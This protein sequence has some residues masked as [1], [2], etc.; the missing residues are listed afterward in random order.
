MSLQLLN[1]EYQ[2]ELTTRRK[3]S[4][5]TTTVRSVFQRIR[6]ENIGGLIRRGYPD[7][8]KLESALARLE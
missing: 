8:R 4:R 3:A 1:E 2:M 7:A 6:I 5:N